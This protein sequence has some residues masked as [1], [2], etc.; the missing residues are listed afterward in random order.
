MLKRHFWVSDGA[1]A[2][3]IAGSADRDVCCGPPRNAGQSVGPIAA[4]GPAVAN[5]KQ[6]AVTAPS[7]A[8]LRRAFLADRI[9]RRFLPFPLQVATRVPAQPGSGIM[10]REP[11][12]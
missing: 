5:P 12:T 8:T 3:V 2:V 10:Q 6:T 11:D 1:F 4:A 7:R 9:M